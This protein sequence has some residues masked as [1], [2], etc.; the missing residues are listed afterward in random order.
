MLPSLLM[1]LLS[2]SVS[3]RAD[4]PASAEQ[5][6]IDGDAVFA[7]YEAR[8]LEGVHLYA[9]NVRRSMDCLSERLSPSQAATAHVAMALSSFLNR[10]NDT[11]QAA[12]RA[13]LRADP[14][15]ALPGGVPVGHPLQQAFEAAKPDATPE[16]TQPMQSDPA[17]QLVVDGR[18]TTQRPTEHPAVLQAVE[19]QQS[20]HSTYLLPKSPLPSWADLDG[21]GASTAAVALP[22]PEPAPDNSG[23][24]SS[25]TDSS[26]TDSSDST[27]AAVASTPAPQELKQEKKKRRGPS[28]GLLIASGGMALAS[29]GLWA[30]TLIDGNAYLDNEADALRDEYDDEDELQDAQDDLDRQYVR[31]NTLGYAAQ[32]ASALT[33][34]LLV[35]AF[36]F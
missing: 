9:S 12:F 25:G 27:N 1:I 20:R 21:G 4:C 19:G 11:T 16:P 29:G 22:R 32:G 14:N 2:T 8:D 33:G 28:P 23:T 18:T 3:A 26:A 13:A 30:A 7:A 17:Y 6:A 36:V 31:V 24:D 34:V 35:S 10:D 15:V 5:V